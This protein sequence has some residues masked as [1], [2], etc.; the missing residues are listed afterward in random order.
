MDKKLNVTE[1]AANHDSNIKH[2]N[3]R[4]E[5]ILEERQVLEESRAAGTQVAYL[6]KKV[7][8]YEDS[9]SQL[10][11]ELTILKAVVE[12]EEEENVKKEEESSVKLEQQMKGIA[13]KYKKSE[14]TES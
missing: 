9:N 13:L 5:C 14:E 11:A 1:V 6:K 2:T 10:R 12:L 7:D 4:I 3:N 8:D